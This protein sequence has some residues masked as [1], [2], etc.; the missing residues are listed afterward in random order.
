MPVILIPVHFDRDPRTAPVS[1]QH[2]IVVRPFITSDFMTGV[3]AVPG[4]D[5][6]EAT[7]LEMARRVEANVVGVSRVLL[8]LTS[9]P[10]GTTEWE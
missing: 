6:P 1:Y 8:D 7:V 3:P 4:K 9:K 2:S 10:P 5:I